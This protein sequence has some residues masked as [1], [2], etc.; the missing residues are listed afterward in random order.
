VKLYYA[1]IL[2]LIMGV[3]VLASQ[4][5][6]GSSRF[7]ARVSSDRLAAV[8]KANS[9]RFMTVVELVIGLFCTYSAIRA[10]IGG[11]GT[12]WL[13]FMAAAAQFAVVALR[14]AAGVKPVP[15]QVRLPHVKMKRNHR[16]ALCFAVPAVV[17]LYAAQPVAGAA[18]RLDNGYIGAAAIV[19]MVAALGGFVAAGW[20]VVWIPRERKPDKDPVAPRRTPDR[21]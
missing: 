11:V 12:W 9:Q 17:C 1:P 18:A 20:A 16:R 6:T 21:H 13:W 8:Q 5:Y 4:A 2:W 10:L 7:R 14:R 15:G 3:L 19:L